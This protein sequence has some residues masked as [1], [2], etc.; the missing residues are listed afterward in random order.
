MLDVLNNLEFWVFGF[1]RKVYLDASQNK[2]LHR[3]RETFQVLSYLIL[4]LSFR[5]WIGLKCLMCVHRIYD[6]TR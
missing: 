5:D 3:G 4:L 2:T 1:D 6:D